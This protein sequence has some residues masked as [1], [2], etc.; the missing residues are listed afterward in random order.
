[1]W[2][3]QADIPQC[4]IGWADHFT[5][6]VF[7]QTVFHQQPMCFTKPSN[8]MKG[9]CSQPEEQGKWNFKTQLV[10]VGATAH[11]MTSVLPVCWI[12]RL[13]TPIVLTWIRTVIIQ[14]LK[15]KRMHSKWQ[16]KFGNDKY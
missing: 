11:K 4:N 5:D 12:V 15:L 16:L 2:V 1:V 9:K 8:K 7:G 6:H 13:K 10:P 3:Q 14:E